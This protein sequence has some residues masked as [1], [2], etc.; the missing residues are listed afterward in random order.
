[1]KKNELIH[2][3][4]CDTSQCETVIVFYK[5][6]NKPPCKTVFVSSSFRQQTLCFLQKVI[7]H[8][9]ANLKWSIE[10]AST[11]LD[12]I[13][14]K[15]KNK[16]KLMLWNVQSLTSLKTKRQIVKS[17]LHCFRECFDVTFLQ[18]FTILKNFWYLIV[19]VR[20]VNTNKYNWNIHSKIYL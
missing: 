19:L 13:K 9:N 3:K 2:Y 20:L 16:H 10:S 7:G 15:N 12:W 1:M 18:Y 5:L 11:W 4:N 8:W 6:I 17:C 14:L